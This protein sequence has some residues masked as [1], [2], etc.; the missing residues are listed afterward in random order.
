MTSIVAIGDIHLHP[1]PRQADR[2]RVLDTI[3]AEGLALDRLGAWLVTG[4]IFHQR[5]TVE[6]RNEFAPRVT[7]MANAAPVFIAWGNHDAPGDLHIF[8][9][10]KTTHPIVVVDSP[11]V[12]RAKFATG[13]MASVFVLPY[14]TKAGL[15]SMGVA[16]GDVVATASEALDFIFMQ[17]ASE[18][19]E[20]RLAGDIT[21]MLAHANIRGAIASNGNPQIGQEI[22]LS[23]EHLDRLGHMPKI[24]GH[25]HKAQT[26]HGAQFVGSICRLSYG[27][28]EEKRYIVIKAVRWE[29]VPEGP[30]F[31]W[32]Y[33]VHSCPID[34]A[35]M[36]HVEGTLTRDGFTWVV[37]DGPS[38]KLQER[39]ESWQGC[40]VRVRYTFPKSERD[41]LLHAQVHA[42]FAEALRLEVEP[43]AAPDRQLRAPAVATART[44]GEKVAAFAQVDSLTPAL[45]TKLAALEHGD[46]VT[47][48]ADLQ[49]QLDQVDAGEA[50]TA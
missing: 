50:V 23:R 3:I 39:P 41:V 40:E 42:E 15:T 43:V 2:L 1:G 21:L 29:A 11:R 31:E 36:Y 7:R 35:P 26:L 20:A 8:T 38:G 32:G 13:D 24:F 47:M 25:I 34:V 12:V 9:K 5:S 4:D 46:A 33:E 14:P 16:K 28:I 37:K 6:D 30:P 17:A 27:E 19:E 10:L 48:L 49:R 18:L 45:S 22:E 44:L